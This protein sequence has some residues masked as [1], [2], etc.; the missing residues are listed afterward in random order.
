MRAD[1][2]RERERAQSKNHSGDVGTTAGREDVEGFLLNQTGFS[3]TAELDAAMKRHQEFCLNLPDGV[4]APS[5]MEFL[6]RRNAASDV[7][8]DLSGEMGGK[9][10]GD[11]AELD[12]FLTSSMDRRNN[13]P[14]DD[15][16]GLSPA[17]M[18]DILS[19]SAWDEG[20]FVVL[21]EKLTDEATL[22]AG[23]VAVSRWLVGF[24][25]DNGGE[26]PLTARGNYNRKLV[27]A[28]V[29]RFDPRYRMFKTV[30]SETTFPFLV[31]AHDLLVDAGYTDESRNRAWLTTEG[32]VL[33]TRGTW[34][35]LY[36]KAFDF[37]LRD[38]DWIDWLDK[39]VRSEHF[40]ILQAAAPF[41]LYLLRRRPEGRLGE[42]FVRV[43]KAF[44][45]Y[46][47]PAKDD[48]DYIDFFANS[49]FYLFFDS[50]CLF[51]GLV[52]IDYDEDRYQVTRLFRE[53]LQWR[54]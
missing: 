26:V 23:V 2:A 41:F 5:F 16:E 39:V 10:F 30:P 51:L 45:L 28:Y 11:R 25:A 6:G 29:K 7:M 54:I 12:F 24:F 40:G 3:S 27:T 43:A 33:H 20:R 52:E 53:A 19:G 21:S 50:F 22:P 47:Q 18:Q 15:F 35:E 13:A 31:A 36:R 34:A 1:E 32:V 49:F 42:I 4:V 44:P 46:I 14:L 38:Y 37:F 8:A 9:V 17:Q 48:L